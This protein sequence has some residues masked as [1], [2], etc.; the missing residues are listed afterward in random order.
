M[1]T[2]R[3]IPVGPVPLVIDVPA[4]SYAT[5]WGS[6]P[7]ALDHGSV[8]RQSAYQLLAGRT[9]HVDYARRLTV[10]A[11]NEERYGWVE[12]VIRPIPGYRKPRTLTGALA[13]VDQPNHL[14]KEA[15]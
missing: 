11:I 8:F 4:N 7:F 5:L 10:R 14:E 2:R 15:A 1:S 9:N 12:V 6:V 3:R 13:P